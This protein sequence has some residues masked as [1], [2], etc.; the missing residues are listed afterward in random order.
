MQIY[1]DGP[2]QIQNTAFVFEEDHQKGQNISTFH[3]RLIFLGD[4]YFLYIMLI[5][6]IRVC[7][8]NINSLK[9]IG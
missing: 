6:L 7:H 3:L 9:K 2:L 5:R 1:F 8:N 4:F